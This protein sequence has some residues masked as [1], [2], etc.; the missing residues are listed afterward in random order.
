MSNILNAKVEMSYSEVQSLIEGKNAAEKAYGELLAASKVVKVGPPGEAL[1]KLNIFARD[2]LDIVRFAVANL[3]P[4][5]T[6]NWPFEALRKLCE[7]V[8]DL[9]D[10]D[11]N[12]H[13]MAIDLKSFVAECEKHELRRKG[14]R[15]AG[16]AR[17]KAERDAR[18]S[19]TLGNRADG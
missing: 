15:A 6:P 14:E 18:V 9:P 12:D 2:A 4:E 8:S 11:T 16:E 3:P 13:D 1:A 10:A 19:E 7:N 17:R 5:M